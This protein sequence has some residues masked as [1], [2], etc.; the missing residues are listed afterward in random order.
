MVIVFS[1]A[2][3]LLEFD[4]MPNGN[5]RRFESHIISQQE[6]IYEIQ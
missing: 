4:R 2:I 1:P 5:H 6:H 3:E